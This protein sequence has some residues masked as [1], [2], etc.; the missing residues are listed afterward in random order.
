VIFASEFEFALSPRNDL[1]NR[2]G[3]PECVRRPNLQVRSDIDNHVR[4]VVSVRETWDLSNRKIDE[5]LFLGVLSECLFSLSYASAA[6]I[7]MI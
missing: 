2:D 3:E 1:H 5:A 7:F 6:A 4:L